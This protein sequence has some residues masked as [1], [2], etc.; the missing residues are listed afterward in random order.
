M[1]DIKRSCQICNNYCFTVIQFSIL[2]IQQSFQ[3][4]PQDTFG[5]FGQDGIIE[6]SP[7]LSAPPAVVSWFKGSVQVLGARFSIASNGSLLISSVEYGDEGDYICAAVNQL[8][9][10]TRT[11]NT[12][13][14]SVYG[15][16]LGLVMLMYHRVL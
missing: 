1:V 3:L 4:P 5:I 12:V 13:H 7:P 9:D 11:S 16:S 6:C 14:F 2:V 10:I 15:R 8:L